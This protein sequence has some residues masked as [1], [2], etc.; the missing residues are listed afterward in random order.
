MI[1]T[2]KKL[3]IGHNSFVIIAFSAF[4]IFFSNFY[5]KK[6]LSP[7]EYG[8]YS[9]F[10]TYLGTLLSF[11][12]LGLE[13]VLLRLSETNE[14]NK[15]CISKQFFTTLILVAFIFTLISSIIFKNFFFFDK[16]GFTLLEI[17]LIS[18]TL[19]ITTLAFNLQ[20]LR[21]L[22]FSS[23]IITNSWKFLL[24][25]VA[26]VYTIFDFKDFNMIFDSLFWFSLIWLFI[27][28]YLILN[29]ITWTLKED[30]K[31]VLSY[32]SNFFIS[33][34]SITLL[35]FIDR[36]A[37]EL[38]LGREELGNYFFLAN[39]FLFPFGLFQNYF[40]FKQLIYYKK[41]F[42]LKL[43]KR[44]ITRAIM[45][46]IALAIALLFFILLTQHID[47]FKINLSK[48]IYL[49]ISLIILGSTRVVYGIISAAVGAQIRTKEFRKLNFFTVISLLL[50]LVLLY[51]TGYTREAILWVVIAMWFSRGI[52]F[53]LSIINKLQS[54]KN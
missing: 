28:S 29:S 10:I 47:W 20:R 48:D 7:L 11:G 37:I 5:F 23:Q 17:F 24:L 19:V 44:D 34:F 13:Q 30:V 21:M 43:L 54:L 22:F 49:I 32:W 3:I 15:V 4:G 25:I 51:F 46:N 52:L 50:L 26:I 14:S 38:R 42:S 35:L 31:E 6:L 39:M 1:A 12:F 9:I 36:Y 18:F 41:S 33:I 45:L 53:Y 8:Q 40:G 27:V 2:I 16:E